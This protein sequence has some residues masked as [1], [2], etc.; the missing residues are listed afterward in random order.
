MVLFT[1]ESDQVAHFYHRYVLSNWAPHQA[2]QP[3]HIQTIVKKSRDRHMLE[4]IVDQ[5]L[6]SRISYTFL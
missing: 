4:S 3:L 5:I 6:K 2:L 1:S